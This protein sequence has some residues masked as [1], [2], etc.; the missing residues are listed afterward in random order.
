TTYTS[1][2]IDSEYIYIGTKDFGVIKTLLSN[3][4]DFQEIHPEGPLL[5]TP[6]SIEATPNNLWVTFGD[7]DIYFNPYPLNSLG[8]SHLKGNEWVN[9]P[10]SAALDAKNLNAISINPFNNNQV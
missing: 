4:V 1:A 6:F 3:P 8:F 10:Y 2:T 9:T 5:S 7:Y